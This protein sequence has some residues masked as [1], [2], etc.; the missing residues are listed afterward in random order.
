[1]D[2]GMTRNV[3]G[4]SRSVGDCAH[5]V[6]E[7]SFHF[8]AIGIDEYERWPRL[9]TAR[10]GAEALANLM[11]DKFGFPAEN[12]RCL[13]NQEATAEGIVGEL[14]A[15]N[16]RLQPADSLLIYYAGH[17]HLDEHTDS[18]AWIPVDGKPPEH[19]GAGATWLEHDRLRK[20]VNK[21]PAR[22]V[23]L[24]SDSC[25]AG[26]FLVNERKGGV[27]YLSKVAN[28]MSR[29][30]LA[31]GGLEPVADGG[32]E[33]HSVFTYWLLKALRE[34]HG[35]Y[36]TAS[37]LAARVCQAV[38]DN[39]DQQPVFFRMT[40]AKGEK[41]GEFLLYPGGISPVAAPKD[42]QLVLDRGIGAKRHWDLVLVGVT[43]AA[44]I[45]AVGLL[46]WRPVQRLNQANEISASE[47]V[48]REGQFHLLRA[49]LAPVDLAGRH[50]S[51]EE[52][53]RAEDQAS[54]ML[55]DAP[56]EDRQ[57]FEVRVQYWRS[58]IDEGRSRLVQT[59][60]D[61]VERAGRSNSVE[62]LRKA[63]EQATRMLRGA[64]KA[65]L[66][67]VNDRVQFFA[68]QLKTPP[69]PPVARY[70]VRWTNSLDEVYVRV[71]GTSVLFA[72]TET[73]I[74]SFRRFQTNSTVLPYQNADDHP[75]AYVTW[76]EATNHAFQLTVSERRAGR[77]RDGDQY[78]LPT[79][80]EWSHAAG[81]GGQANAS[82][83]IKVG[84]VQ[85][86]KRQYWWQKGDSTDGLNLAGDELTTNAPFSH[87]P[88]L[89]GFKDGFITTAPAN[90]GPVNEF[91]LH[92]LAG[93]LS[94]WCQNADGR[95][96]KRWARG[97]S[98]D[99]GE[100]DKLNKEIHRGSGDGKADRGIG[101]RLVFEPEDEAR[102]AN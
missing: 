25:F 94:E 17:G 100:Q 4:A 22:H 18:G 82:S 30:V 3:V 56:A 102:T 15:L 1:M 28:L 11:I 78:R 80:D 60:L 26:D 79:D 62:E 52:L 29:Q 67:Q 96:R 19:S 91:G 39:S 57:R 73:T 76:R 75:V 64:P 27:Q 12:V 21:C 14:V 72:T 93:N 5:P 66:E 9:G 63:E 59:A 40:R 89:Q 47:I 44:V 43:V 50:N 42:A 68:S 49:A 16:Q 33:G 97:A 32:G 65:D 77:I 98:W 99:T 69:S 71:P 45:S 90:S 84:G 55:L 7:G 10:V 8:L 87:L 54:G 61:L 83:S 92:H 86:P 70:G 23:L 24:I 74:R 31:A 88:T 85:R 2:G 48:V 34:F 36:L 46:G 13:L 35:E 6:P 20:I 58:R 53:K 38:G 41:G 51:V 81:V 95:G 37:R 101:F